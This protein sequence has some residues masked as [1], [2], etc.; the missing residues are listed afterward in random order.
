MPSGPYVPSARR[1]T[2]VPWAA[3]QDGFLHRVAHRG[4]AEPFVAVA[5]SDPAAIRTSRAGRLLHAANRGF[6]GD[7]YFAA[8]IMA[9]EPEFLVHA[10]DV[11]RSS[12]ERRQAIGKA[13]EL[14]R[15]RGEWAGSAA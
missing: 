7:L 14:E 13:D 12:P 8:R 3:V 9:T 1:P 15:L 11:Y 4:G 6:G 5:V 10:I 2:F